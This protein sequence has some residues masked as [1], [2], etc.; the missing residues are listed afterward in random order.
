MNYYEVAPNQ[1]VRIGSDVFTY[2]STDIFPVGSLVTIPIGKK[3]LIG[4]VMKKVAK[5]SYATKQIT[6]I[7]GDA[8]LPEPLVELAAWLASYYVTPLAIVWQ[9][10]L[11]RGLNKDRR[12][13]KTIPHTTKRDRTT[14]VFN[15]EQ[16]AVIKRIESTENGT[17]LLQ[18]IT[19]SGKTEVYIEIAKQALATGKSAIILVPEI[20]LTSQIV[21]EFAN[22]FEDIIITH[23]TMTEAQRH[24][25]WKQALTSPTPLIVIGPR[26]ALF[27]PLKNIGIIVVDEAHE[28]SY[29][30]EQAPRYSAVRAATMLGRFHNAKVILGS[31]TPAVVDRYVAE[32]SGRPILKLT[33]S[34]RADT[35]KSNVTLIDMTKLSS[36]KSH[37]FLSTELIQQIETTLASGK[38]SLIFHNR[39]GSA[40]T[41]LCENCGWTAL[42]PRCFVPLT[43]H[44]DQHQLRCHICDHSERIPTMCPVCNHVDIIHKGIGTKLIE[45]ELHKL[46][47]DATIARFDQDNKPD[48]TVNA[49]YGE[50]Y[51]GDIDI[52]IGTQVVAKGLDLPHLRLVGIIQADSGLSLPDYSARERTFQLIAQVVGRVGRNSHA[53]NVIIQTYQPTHPSIVAGI[54]QD[55][56]SFYVS[57][58]DGRRRGIFPPFTYLLKL[59]NSYKTESGAIMSAKKLAI[60]L[61]KEFGNAITIL[62]PTPSFYERQRDSY[63]WQ[64]IIKSSKR[65]QL[66]HV[67]A[68]LPPTHWQAELDPTSLL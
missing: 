60:D 40:A 61:Q 19:G 21:A 1:I 52:A 66:M 33:K 62:G 56:E 49:R 24:A 50:L 9:T 46:F 29:K 14:I 64:L 63:R 37:R 34:A 38:Q 58:L 55:Y 11:P 39:R 4:V 26:S 47:P 42:C 44:I 31:A 22:H 35:A 32:Q 28:P 53:S 48:E 59:T 43:L 17:L 7:I 54:T 18:G 5:P 30:Q 45:S 36:R 3:E 67:Q 25:V 12:A 8:H 68:S 10:I 16:A 2:E 13:I 57:E 51:K 6:S 23:S 41:T 15:E 65:E 27:I 20:A